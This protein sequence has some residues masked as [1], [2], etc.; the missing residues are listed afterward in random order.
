MNITTKIKLALVFLVI[1]IV[2]FIFV[3]KT[4]TDKVVIDSKVPVKIDTEKKSLTIVAFGD[5]LTA[6]YGVSIE[7]SYP[8][9]LEKKLNEYNIPSKVI[10]MGVSGETTEI[11]LERLDFVNNQNPDYVLIGLGAN[12]MLRSMPPEKAKENLEKIIIF[13][14]EK[15]R[16]IILLGM[17]S[18]PTNGAAY[19]KA[20]N[21]IYSDLSQKYS[22][23]LVPFFLEGVA[24]RREFNLSDG[25]HPNYSGY[26]KI[27][28]DNLLPVILKY[29]KS[30]SPLAP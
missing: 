7:E 16:K 17:N 2:P 21:S 25:I 19:I 3:Y 23:P 24:L 13:F 29:I 12:D 18:F 28:D 6:G 20:F 9:I 4:S 8:A 11:A 27:V 15:D 22:L 26:Q 10:N 5:S 30:T 1:A 14:K